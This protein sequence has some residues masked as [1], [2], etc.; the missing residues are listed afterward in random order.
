MSA[1]LVGLLVGVGLGMLYLSSRAPRVRRTLASSL[2][3]GIIVGL[4]VE[5]ARRPV[6]GAVF[7]GAA[8]V[9]VAEFIRWVLGSA[10][11]RP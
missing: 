10:R 7:A 3:L 2:L 9:F 1:L 6:L 4:L 11:R 5:L 8:T